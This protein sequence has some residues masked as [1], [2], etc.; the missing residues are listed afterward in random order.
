MREWKK[1]LFSFGKSI[2]ELF[3]IYVTTKLHRL[4]RSVFNHIVSFGCV[5]TGSLEEK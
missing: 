1:Y 3:D 5:I 2:K 4:M